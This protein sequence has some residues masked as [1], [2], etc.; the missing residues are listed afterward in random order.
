[1]TAT[2]FQ[3]G[4]RL[5]RNATL[6]TN[7]LLIEH[8][9]ERPQR[10]L[11]MSGVIHRRQMT[12][13]ALLVIFL[14]AFALRVMAFGNIPGGIQHDEV[15][16][17]L[18][19]KQV[20]AGYHALYFYLPGFQGREPVMAYFQA[21]WLRLVGENLWGLR[22]LSTV[23]GVLTVALVHAAGRRLFDRRTAMLATVTTTCAFW[24][25]LISRLALRGALIPPLAALSVYLFWRCYTDQRARTAWIGA[26]L[27]VAVACYT[28]LAGWAIP[29]ALLMFTSYLHWQ[30][31][32]RLRLQRGRIF[33]YGAVIVLT[34]T[35]LVF[36]IT[37]RPEG[38]E[39]VSQLSSLLWS[40]ASGDV[41]PL[42]SNTL[43][44]LDL[45]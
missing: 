18:H 25:L 34:L 20:L 42:V 3:R 37:Q 4:C 30:D 38:S 45:R 29:C 7:N 12:H 35:P 43:S 13:S 24:P 41:W 33:G 1:M 8:G 27:T 23:S 2:K 28:Y 17:A 36:A 10:W 14:L 11:S 15:T 22:F 39:R 19:A 26:A 40:A 44:V 16:E 31:R 5:R 21:L 6:A 9:R 32:P